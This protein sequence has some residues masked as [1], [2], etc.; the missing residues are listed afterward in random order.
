MNVLRKCCYRSLKENKRRTAV[1]LVGIILA[2]S[3][4]TAVACMAVSFR[5]SMVAYEKQ[6]TGDWHYLFQGVRA[7]DL[8]YFRNNENVERMGLTQE[9]GY[10]LLEGSQNPDKPYLYLRATDQEGQKAMA[11]KLVEGRMPGSWR[12][13]DMSP[14]T[15]WW[16]SRWGM[17]SPF[18]WAAAFPTEF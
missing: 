7:G 11:L 18:R 6:Q 9:V 12:W 3:L 13:P 17:S 15:A 14:P 8:K 5:V 4:L 2:T 16:I 1:T 10:G